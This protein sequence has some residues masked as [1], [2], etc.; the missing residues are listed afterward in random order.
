[1][2]IRWIWAFLD[3]PVAQFEECI[4][5]WTAV[6]HT[7]VSPRRG[8]FGEF[9]TLLPDSGG[10][11][12]KMQAV[13]GAPRVHMDLDV[14]DIAAA[15]EQAVRFGATLVLDNPD[16]AVLK[17][18]HDMIFC[19][20]PADPT[21]GE[22]TA[23]VT[24]PE[25]DTSRVDQITLDIGASDHEAEVRFWT[26]L[27]G[28]TWRPGTLTEYSRLVP[29]SPLPI[30]LLLQRLDEDRPTSAHLDL[31]CTDTEAT[32]AWHE[33]LGAQRIERGKRWIV[34]ADPAGQPYCLTGRTP[35]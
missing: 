11:A 4:E 24:G 15:T 29:D 35:A 12:I 23:V 30:N 9:V 2:T 6:T 34:M 31:S 17:S 3:R 8:E 13:S 22:L 1:M 14:D 33:K 7:T 18:P 5:F 16:C 27:T 28:W 26:A 20:T 19:F 21:Q 10:P 25:G 32:A